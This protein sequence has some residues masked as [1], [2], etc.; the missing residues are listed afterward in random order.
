MSK[1]ICFSTA[2]RIGVLAAVISLITLGCLVGCGNHQEPS[3][4]STHKLVVGATPSPHAEI[5]NSVKDQLKEEGIELE[6]HE[7]TD[8][9]IPNRALTEG[10][11]D[12]NFFQHQPFLDDY[13]AHDGTD[14]APVAQVHFEALGIYQGTVHTLDELPDG[15][16]VALPNDTTNEARALHLLEDNG[17]ITLPHDAGLNVT[18]KDVVDNPKHLEFVE[19]EAAAI[20]HAIPD[21]AIAVLNGNFALS[22]GIDPA[23]ALALED[24]RSLAAKTY[25]NIVVVR[26]GD[27]NR[28]EIQALVRALH[29]EQTRSFIQDTYKGLVVPVF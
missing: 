17:L 19:L 14:L 7:Y 2:S 5:L 12:A 28:P 13:N 9:T 26:K 29:S 24:S 25:A 27:E 20:P 11:D 23:T 3:G 16:R 22:A 21:V 6:V 8:Y 4:G 1:N 18:A 15:A 10:A